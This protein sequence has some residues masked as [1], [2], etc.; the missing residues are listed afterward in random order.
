MREVKG[1]V[2]TEPLLQSPE[3]CGGHQRHA[4]VFDQCHF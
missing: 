2:A 1:W 3:H 4:Q